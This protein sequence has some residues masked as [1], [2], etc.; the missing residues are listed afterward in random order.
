MHITCRKKNDFKTDYVTE[1]KKIF[2]HPQ[3]ETL[4]DYIV[5]I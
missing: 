2:Y 4:L 5:N 1:K 3:E